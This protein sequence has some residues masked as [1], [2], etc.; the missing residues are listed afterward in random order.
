[1]NIEDWNIEGI[2]NRVIAEMRQDEAEIDDV[3]KR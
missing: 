3:Y 1:M 2:A